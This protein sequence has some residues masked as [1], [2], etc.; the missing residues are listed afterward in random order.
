LLPNL[1]IT[2]RGRSAEKNQP[3]RT[4][5]GALALL[6]GWDVSHGA[7][8]ER[9]KH[10]CTSQQCSCN[11]VRYYCWLVGSQRGSSQLGLVLVC[12]CNLPERLFMVSQTEKEGK[13]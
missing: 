6:Y 4:A 8:Y 3:A 7:E 11:S 9:T 12:G 13:T 1:A 2:E 5:S 10:V